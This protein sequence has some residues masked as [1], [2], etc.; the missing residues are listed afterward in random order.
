MDERHYW[1]DDLRYIERWLRTF[2]GD[3]IQAH[4]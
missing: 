2:F 3:T 4:F 1:M